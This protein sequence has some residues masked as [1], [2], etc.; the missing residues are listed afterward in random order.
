MRVVHLGRSTCHAISGRH[1][2]GEGI[3]CPLILHACGSL[4]RLRVM[5]EFRV[6]GSG[7]RAWGLGL[8]VSGVGFRVPGCGLRV[9]GS[10][11]QAPGF[12]LRD[13]DSG[14]RVPGI[15]GVGF[16]SRLPVPPRRFPEDRAACMPRG[17]RNPQRC[18][19]PVG[20]RCTPLTL[21]RGLKFR[22]ES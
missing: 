9:A 10:R 19:F 11:F 13:P 2:L 22:G 6:P 17:P 21:M 7:F 8:R 3:C 20:R 12:G 4:L 16:G 14:F 1:G 15:A 5:A 18:R